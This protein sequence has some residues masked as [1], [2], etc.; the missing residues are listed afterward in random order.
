MDN[1]MFQL[2]Q[3]TSMKSS[4]KNKSVNNLA[5]T[6]DRELLAFKRKLKAIQK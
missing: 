6:K 5:T 2:E 1:N 3:I 4:E